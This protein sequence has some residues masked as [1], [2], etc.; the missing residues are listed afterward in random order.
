MS[1]RAGRKENPGQV[2][3]QTHQ[4]NHPALQYVVTNNYIE[5]Y[6]GQI[7]ERKNFRYPPVYRLIKITMKH[8]DFK[9]LN[10]GAAAMGEKLRKQFP[11]CVL[12]PEYPLVSKIQNQYLKELYL[13]FPKDGHVEFKKK[14]L[15]VLIDQL[16]SDSKY[17]SIR[18][19]V[20][21]DC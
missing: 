7:E 15:Q 2:V 16:K 17:K 3:V 9:L 14:Q 19:I 18:I 1:G 11:D 20:N 12:G 10:F 13:K 21:V 4:P 6:R 5:M 8:T